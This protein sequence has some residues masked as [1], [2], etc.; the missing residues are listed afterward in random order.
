[1]S[2]HDTLIRI[3]KEQADIFKDN[4]IVYVECL[5]KFT[6]VRHLLCTLYVHLVGINKIFPI[7]NISQEYKEDLKSFTREIN[8]DRLQS[9]DAIE[10][11]KSLYVLNYL[12]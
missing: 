9:T 3:G 6:S 1:M 7:E 5:V 10:L 8:K 11:A 4:N 12:L 2:L